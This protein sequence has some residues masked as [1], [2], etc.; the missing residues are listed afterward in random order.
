MTYNLGV[1]G[2]V[3]GEDF[4]RPKQISPKSFKYFFYKLSPNIFIGRI[5]NDRAPAKRSLS[6]PVENHPSSFGD[7]R[8]GVIHG[9]TPVMVRVI[10][11]GIYTSVVHGLTIIVCNIS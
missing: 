8:G 6:G 4:G 3:E 7:R 9:P 10:Y 5:H 11:I 1:G 2:G